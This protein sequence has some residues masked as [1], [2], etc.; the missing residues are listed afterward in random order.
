[1]S[2]CPRLTSALLHSVHAL[3]IP[4][5]LG[6]D[7]VSRSQ[8][9][10]WSVQHS[11]CGLECAIVVSKWLADVVAMLPANSLTGMFRVGPN[12]RT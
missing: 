10:F 3:S 1:M 8:A 6:I 4:V 11:I 12:E 5:K 2:R 7:Y 9:F